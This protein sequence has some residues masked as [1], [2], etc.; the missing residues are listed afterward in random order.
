MV[1]FTEAL[2]QTEIDFFCLDFAAYIYPILPKANERIVTLTVSGKV[3]AREGEYF[4]LGLTVNSK[5]I[6]LCAMYLI[7]LYIRILLMGCQ[8]HWKHIDNERCEDW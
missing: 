3:R 7:C 6:R 4:L 2:G 5:H 1:R 8:L